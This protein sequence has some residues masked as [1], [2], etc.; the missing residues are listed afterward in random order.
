[1]YKYTSMTLTLDRQTLIALVT[2]TLVTYLPRYLY[3]VV[4]TYHYVVWEYWLVVQVGS[5]VRVVA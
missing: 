5:D 2:L 3:V 1:M 4:G